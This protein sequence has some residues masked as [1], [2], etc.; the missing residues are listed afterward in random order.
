[1]QQNSAE[2]FVDNWAY[3]RAEL[4]WL[5]RLLGVAVARQRQET[6]E[7]DR[8]ARNRADRA[9]SHWWR[10]LVSL[11]GEGASDSP[12][13]MPRSRSVRGNFQQQLEAK[14]RASEQKGIYLGIPSLCQHLHLTTF[15]KNLVLMALAPEIN[16]RY[17]RIYNYLQE[18]E[19]PSAPGLPTVELVL[20]ILCR[21]DVEWRSARQSLAAD[22]PLVRHHLLEVRAASPL[23]QGSHQAESLLTRLVKLTDP[24]VNF[25]LADQPNPATLTILL[26][27]PSPPLPLSPSRSNPQSFPH[28]PS[29]YSPSWSDLILPDTLL[30][31]LQHLC[32]RIQFAE[33]VDQLWGFQSEA[34]PTSKGTAALLIGAAGTGK[35][36]AAGVIARELEQ[37][38]Q[39][40]NLTHLHLDQH[41]Q[42]IWQVIQEAPRLL[43]VKSAEVWLGQASSLEDVELQLFLEQRRQL[44][45]I[46]LFSC[47]RRQSIRPFWRRHLQILEFPFPDEASRLK[48]WQRA[49]PASAPLDG[50]IDWNLL[51]RQFKLAGGD[52]RAIAREAA[53]YAAAETGSEKIAMRHLLQAC[54]TWKG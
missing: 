31:D 18:A 3:L 42:F 30:K 9:T 20:R 51:A 34:M 33:Q 1:M 32:H 21:N 23:P 15:E 17:G 37:P 44:A 2:P 16:R 46:T 5:D 28:P 38:V 8:F 40:V 36:T 39:I 52:I 4:G 54:N 11:E 53:I 24:L 45:S 19:Y 49:F 35:T 10:G 14:I 7:V 29:P 25:L 43:L 41:L 47:N 48:L 12:A 13:E 27:P 6:K 22:S 50:N 26:P